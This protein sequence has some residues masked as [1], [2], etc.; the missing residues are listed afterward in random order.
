VQE[1]CAEA[2][3]LALTDDGRGRVALDLSSKDVVQ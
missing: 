1:D 3:T 2:G